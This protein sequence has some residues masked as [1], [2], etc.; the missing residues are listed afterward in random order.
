MLLAAVVKRRD[1]D[2]K[3]KTAGM[4]EKKVEVGGPD[5]PGR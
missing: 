3:Q 2:R 4:F 5:E 1:Y